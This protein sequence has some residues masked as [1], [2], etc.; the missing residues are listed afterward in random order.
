[1]KYVDVRPGRIAVAPPHIE[2]R[3]TDMSGYAFLEQVES[4]Y[5]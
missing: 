4:L 3:A 1:M 5:L 2:H